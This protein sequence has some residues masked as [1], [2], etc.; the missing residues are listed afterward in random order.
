MKKPGKIEESAKAIP[1]YTDIYCR[2]WWVKKL[3]IGN[4]K[5]R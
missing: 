3:K 2:G 4:K 1:I 5:K